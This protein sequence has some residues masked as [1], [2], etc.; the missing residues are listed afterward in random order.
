M[1]NS[2]FNVEYIFNVTTN[3]PHKSIHIISSNHI[4]KFVYLDLSVAVLYFLCTAQC[5]SH[6]TRDIYTTCIN[7]HLYINHIVM[8]N[9]FRSSSVVCFTPFQQPSAT[10]NTTLMQYCTAAPL[11]TGRNF[12]V[13]HSNKCTFCILLSKICALQWAYGCRVC[14]CAPVQ[15]HVCGMHD[16]K[17]SRKFHKSWQ[18]NDGSC[19]LERA[20]RTNLAKYHSN[21]LFMIIIIIISWR[22]WLVAYDD[23]GDDDDD[24]QFILHSVALLCE[25]PKWETFRIKYSCIHFPYAMGHGAFHTT[26]YLHNG[27][28]TC[29]M[30][31]THTFIIHTTQ[32]TMYCTRAQRTVNART[33]VW[34]ITITVWY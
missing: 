15:V 34:V 24:A 16:G 22:W 14:V 8:A 32:T 7:I 19:G 9:A 27:I 1:C 18:L 12:H 23:A 20:H 21:G 5:V 11:S 29:S 31:P 26:Y 3:T 28:H 4:T 13:A 2:F 10:P 6:R 30:Y 17:I 33:K 25:T